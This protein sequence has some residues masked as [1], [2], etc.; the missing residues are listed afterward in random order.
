MLLIFLISACTQQTETPQLDFA[1][2]DDIRCAAASL[3]IDTV[4]IYDKG[5]ISDVSI[6]VRNTGELD[7]LAILDARVYNISGGSASVD[8]NMLV[9]DFDRREVITLKIKNAPI[10]SCQN[11]SKAAVAAVCGGVIDV[12]DKEK[13]MPNCF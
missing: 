7:N 11:F 8:K 3:K 1:E 6:I 12:F 4:N 10:S 5:E 2:S 9:V 13:R